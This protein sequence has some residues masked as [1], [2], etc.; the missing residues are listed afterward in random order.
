MARRRSSRSAGVLHEP[1]DFFEILMLFR[2]IVVTRVLA[3]T[4]A[5]RRTEALLPILSCAKSSTQ[6]SI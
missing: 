3:T 5:C 1:T 6:L 4:V 2:V